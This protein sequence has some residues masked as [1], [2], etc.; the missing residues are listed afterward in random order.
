MI[1]INFPMFSFRSLKMILF[2]LAAILLM[3]F[4]DRLGWLGAPR[5][6]A[7]KIIEPFA[8]FLNGSCRFLSDKFMVVFTL[9]DLVEENRG[10]RSHNLELIAQNTALREKEKEN[11]ILRN[12]LELP[13]ESRF[14]S[15]MA[16]IIGF[17][18]EGGDCLIINKGKNFGLAEGM[19]AV[20]SQNFLVGKII[21]AGSFYSKVLLITS[22]QSAVN[23]LSQETRVRGMVRG[24]QG[25]G[26]AM[27]MIPIAQ[28]I[29]E[30]ETVITS[31]LNDSAPQ[32][33]IIGSVLKIFFKETEIFKRA[34]IKPAADF[35]NLEKIF[36]VKNSRLP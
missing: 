34:E 23:S 12:R 5:N 3:V 19:F 30:N 16:Q 29:K 4:F 25:L 22:G 21:E 9:N 11:E 36:I 26:L 6:A 2:I 33:L 13:I 27:E 8:S 14:E 1:S 35:K 32:G 20:T 17:G 15:E 7:F 24:D 31:G 18:L 28:E 10:L